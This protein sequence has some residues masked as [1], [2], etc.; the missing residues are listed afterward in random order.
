MKRTLILCIPLLAAF[1]F[2]CKK[3]TPDPLPAAALDKAFAPPDET[4]GK[5]L[6][7]AFVAALPQ[8][9]AASARASFSDTPVAEGK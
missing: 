4:T 6:I 3:E 8:D 9:G 2:G 1:Y 5:R 7:A